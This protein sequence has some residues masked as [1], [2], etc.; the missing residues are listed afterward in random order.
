MMQRLLLSVLI[1]YCWLSDVA[2]AFRRPNRRLFS[3]VTALN[4]AMIFN[5]EYEHIPGHPTKATD[6]LTGLVDSMIEDSD[7]FIVFYAQWCPDCKSVP[8]IV[9]GLENANVENVVM[10]DIG[11]EKD[12]WRSGEHM[13]K[14][15]PLNLKGR[16]L[17]D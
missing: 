8:S 16:S 2:I 4:T 13:Y 12:L 3:P 6:N 9:Q 1:G 14:Q 10:C 11:D 7:A 15:A 5:F 17:S